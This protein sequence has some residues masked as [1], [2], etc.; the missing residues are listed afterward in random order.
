MKFKPHNYQAKAIKH[1][2]SNPACGL[3]LDMGLGKT[4]IT[5]TA[6]KRLLYDELDITRVLVIAPL[7]VA[8]STWEDEAAKWEHTRGLKFSLVLGT[9]KQRERALGVKDADIYVI[10]REN[11][12]WLVDRYKPDKF[13]FDCWIL[14][15]SSSFKNPNAQRFRWL[16]KVRKCAKRVIA[17]TG[18]PVPNG[19]MDIWAQLF[20]LDGGQRLEKYIS[21]YRAKYFV[22]AGGQGHIVY[23]YD[24]QPGADKIILGKIRDICLSMDAKDYLELPPVTVTDLSVDI[25]DKARKLYKELREERIIE[26][27]SSNEVITTKTAVELLGKLTQIANGGIYY[28]EVEGDPSTRRYEEVHAAK[29][30]ALDEIIES[31]NGAPVLVAYTFQFDREL[32]KRRFGSKVRE[33]K[34]KRDVDDWNNGDIKILLTHPASAAYGLNM[35]RG[36]NICVWYG[37][38]RSL[39]L[40]LQF[41]ARLHRQGQSKPVFI[42][43]IIADKTEDDRIAKSLAGKDDLQDGFLKDLKKRVEEYKNL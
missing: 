38:T 15:E 2:L 21:H 30:D 33:L 24:L 28:E 16:K 26:L 13:P 19:L 35:Q 31:A 18:T 32:I 7:R 10:N 20:L 39:E 40:Y 11:V 5:L 43:R 4:I 27:A 34:S 17:L 3:F 9:A 8:Q 25:G 29:L 41:N 42:Y 14:D 6:V 23:D 37:L 36:G 22:P 12:K 1:A